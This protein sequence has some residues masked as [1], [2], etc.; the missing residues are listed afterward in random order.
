MKK[1]IVA[2]LLPLFLVAC[3]TAPVEP[4]TA[5]GPDFMARNAAVKRVVSLP[6]GV[7]YFVLA[8]GPE[9]GTRPKTGDTVSF[10]YEGKLTTGETFDSSF[11][12]G[13]SL[14]G[15][16]GGFVPGF[17]EALT[18]MRP[19]DDWIVWIPPELGYGGEDKGPIPANSILRFRLKLNSVTPAP[20]A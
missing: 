8:S 17:N 12:R 7:Q 20:A 15:E 5:A 14:S 10:D 19:G 9:T 6:S 4:Q 18:L 1:S 3:A 13:E 2:A 16:V 11:E